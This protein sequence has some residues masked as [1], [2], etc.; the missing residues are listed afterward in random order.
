[1]CLSSEPASRMQTRLQKQV[2]SPGREPEGKPSLCDVTQ[3]I[4]TPGK[5]GPHHQDPGEN[6]VQLGRGA[7]THAAPTCHA[8]KGD[9][10]AVPPAAC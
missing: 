6:W 1:M 2:R 8:G 4:R 9:T 3:G 5:L 7:I 10:P